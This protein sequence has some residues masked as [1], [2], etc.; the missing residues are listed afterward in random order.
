MAVD[1][2]LG[3]VSAPREWICTYAMLPRWGRFSC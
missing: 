2:T 3:I 1:I